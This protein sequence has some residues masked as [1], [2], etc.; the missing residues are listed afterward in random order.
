[1]PI[2]DPSTG[3][4]LPLD[5]L[6]GGLLLIKVHELRTGISTTFGDA[7][8][9]SCDVTALDGN[10]QGETFEDTLVFPRV[11][12]SQL[13]K[14]IG[15][16]VL[17]RLGQGVKKPGQSPPWTLTAATDAEKALAE[18]HLAAAQT[19]PIDEDSIV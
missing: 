12:I 7:D 14:H 5:E 13:R 19:K 18:R 10:H 16:M 4:R 8:A 3:D 17:G 15:S 9:I 11:L 2:N 1:M 6:N